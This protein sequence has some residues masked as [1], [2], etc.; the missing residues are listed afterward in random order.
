[1]IDNGPTSQHSK[2]NYLE[3]G[4]GG[5]RVWIMFHSGRGGGAVP[6]FHNSC[7]LKKKN[8]ISLNRL[9]LNRSI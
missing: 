8:H 3:G 1:M 4:K 5:G 7:V 2:L 6:L 9:D